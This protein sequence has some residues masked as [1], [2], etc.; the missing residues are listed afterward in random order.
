MEPAGVFECQSQAVELSRPAEWC[1]MVEQPPGFRQEQVLYLV[2]EVLGMQALQEEKQ[3]E[4]PKDLLEGP[5]VL[6]KWQLESYFPVKAVEQTDSPEQH[7][8]D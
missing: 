7:Q 4:L 2:M 1:R 3:E 6:W 5:E 8:L